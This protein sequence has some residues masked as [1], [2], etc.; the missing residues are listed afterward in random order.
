[1]EQAQQGMAQQQQG[2]GGG[3][4]GPVPGPEGGIP[5]V[6]GPGFDPNQGGIPPAMANPKATREMQTGQTRTGEEVLA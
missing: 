3:Q 4:P 5:G 2:G 6:G 1:M